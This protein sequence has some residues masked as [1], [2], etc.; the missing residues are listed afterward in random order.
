MFLV[1]HI[2]IAKYYTLHNISLKLYISL[3]YLYNLHTKIRTF[4]LYIQVYYQQQ[5]RTREYRD[6]C[7]NK[8]KVKSMYIYKNMQTSFP[9]S[10]RRAAT[11][12]Q[13]DAVLT[14]TGGKPPDRTRHE[15]KVVRKIYDE[16]VCG[17][18]RA[19]RQPA[20]ERGGKGLKTFCFIFNVFFFNLLSRFCQLRSFRN[21]PRPRPLLGRAP[22]KEYTRYGHAASNARRPALRTLSQ[23]GL[24]CSRGRPSPRPQNPPPQ[25]RSW[26]WRAAELIRVRTSAIRTPSP[27]AN[28]PARSGKSD[29]RAG[30][31]AKIQKFSFY[32]WKPSPPF[33]KTADLS[34]HGSFQDWPFC[35]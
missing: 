23:Q 17:L 31:G 27:S 15:K 34:S 14:T 13:H 29:L 4:V 18:L 32:C 25:R 2:N 7:K 6:I 33:A 5:F 10:G 30:W 28:D 35:L 12:W 19:F 26:S 9:L 22:E 1:K 3:R 16:P 20:R 11:G 21:Y 24:S 8:R